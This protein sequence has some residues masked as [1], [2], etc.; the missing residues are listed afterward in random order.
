MRDM[1]V[2]GTEQSGGRGADGR[3]RPVHLCIYRSQQQLQVLA[4]VAAPAED[5]RDGPAPCGGGRQ[6]TREVERELHP[7]P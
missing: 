6:R 3:R 1:Q 5:A 2:G 7:S 4:A